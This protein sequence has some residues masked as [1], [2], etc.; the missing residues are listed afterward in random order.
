[1]KIIIFYQYSLFFKFRDPLFIEKLQKELFFNKKL[2]IFN[3][4]CIPN[5]RHFFHSAI[6]SAKS[7]A[8]HL[9]RIPTLE[10]AIKPNIQLNYRKLEI[11]QRT[12]IKFTCD[13]N[14]GFI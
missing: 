5:I 3:F 11:K 6:L 7:N 14:Q 2:Q 1:L 12:E 9:P 13:E 8:S 10:R 4:N